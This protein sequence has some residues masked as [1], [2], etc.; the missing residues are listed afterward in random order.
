MLSLTEAPHICFIK[1]KIG[2][3]SFFKTQLQ[4]FFIKVLKLTV[5][6]IILR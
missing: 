3:L 5:N 2:V 6:A 4:K 1:N